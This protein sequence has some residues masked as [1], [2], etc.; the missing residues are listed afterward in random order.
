MSCSTRRRHYSSHPVSLKFGCACYFSIYQYDGKC[1]ANFASPSQHLSL[2][3][4]KSPREEDTQETEQVTEGEARA[5]SK[6]ELLT[7]ARAEA[8][9]QSRK[10]TR[11]SNKRHYSS[12]PVYLKFG[13]AYYF[14]IYQNGGSAH[15]FRQVALFFRTTLNPP[16][17][18]LSL[19]SQSRQKKGTRR[20]RSNRQ[21]SS[22]SSQL[23]NA[24]T[25]KRE[26]WQLQ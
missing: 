7:R 4:P 20:E 8:R 18:H 19:P 13:R 12:H 3:R 26:Q 21:P 16:P 24:A 2:T 10:E 22:L 15:K 5:A 23:G 11:S 14:C 1:Y 25:Q 6:A 9:V 17:Q